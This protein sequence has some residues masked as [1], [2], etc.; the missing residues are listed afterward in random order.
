[1]KLGAQ[2]YTVRDFCKTPED[3]KSSLEKVRA[4]GYRAVQLSAHNPEIPA[5]DIA[6]WCAELDLEVACTHMAWQKYVDNLQTVIDEHKIWDCK[7][8]GVGSMPREYAQDAAGFERFAKEASAIAK[9]LDAHGLHFIYHNHAFEFARFG[10][11]TGM[12]I[13]LRDTAPEFQFELDTHWVQC[14]GGDPA[15]WIYKVEGRMDVVHFKDMAASA[16]RKPVICEIGEGNLNW[17]A[18]IGACLE[19]GVQYALVEQD[20]STRDPFES[21]AMSFDYLASRGVY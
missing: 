15:A 6:K 3:M 12:D 19:T 13:L 20:V 5:E 21:L 16:E 4:I 8:P 2:L 1:M 17:D 10:R 14:G 18:I 11:L 9:K 7:Y